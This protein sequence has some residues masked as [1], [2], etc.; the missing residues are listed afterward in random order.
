[1]TISVMRVHLNG[2]N[3]VG[4]PS[5]QYHQFAWSGVA[6]NDNGLWTS[7]GCIPPAGP[8]IFQWQAWIAAGFG[9][10][11]PSIVVKLIKNATVDGSG[12]L[13]G[14]TG[15]IIAA[16]GYGTPLELL[17]TGYTGSQPGTAVAGA[18]VSD[19]ANG[20][21]TYNLFIYVTAADTSVGC[22][23]DGNPAHTFFSA[24]SFG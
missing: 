1:M 24:T 16:I 2:T 19:V 12:N 13:N 11:N 22:T 3:Q 6:Q 8:V 18:S 4:I 23:I 14:E 20:T 7:T 10:S 5:D 21:D 15:D 17:D 9:G